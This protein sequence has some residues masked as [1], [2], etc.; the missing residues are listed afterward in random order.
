MSRPILG[1]LLTMLTIAAAIVLA[2]L[3][4]Q[5]LRIHPQTDDAEVFANLIGIAPEVGGRIIK[6]NVKD[7]QFVH[8]GDL[9]FQIDPVPYQYVLETAR[10]QQAALEGQIRDLG[11]TIGAQTSAIEVA[12]AN[13]NSAQAKTASADAAIGAARAGVDAAKAELSRQRADYAYAENNV[14]R[15]EPLLVQQFVT[16]DMVD[17]ART[18]RSVKGEAVR[19]ARSRLELA[20][21]Q[22]AAAIAQQKEAQATY[23]QSH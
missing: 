10:S 16:V 12:R 3:V 4:V 17:Q 13:S 11:R 7:N 23:Q 9:L 5:R 14:L 1:R 19:Q 8:K 22:W 18:S 15:L 6:I 21:A 20:E 2:L